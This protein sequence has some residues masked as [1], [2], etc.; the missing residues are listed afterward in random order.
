MIIEADQTNL[1]QAAVIHSVSWQESHRAFCSPDFI[2]L[3]SPDHQLE[4]I[5][6]KMSTGKMWMK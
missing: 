1:L 4:Y 5:S 2:E 3:H 6:E